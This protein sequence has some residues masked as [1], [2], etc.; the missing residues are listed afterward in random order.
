MTSTARVLLGFAVIGTSLLS[1]SFQLV[2]AQSAGDA[3]TT[4]EPNL[5]EPA[6]S[7]EPASEA[8]AL[9]IELTPTRVDVVPSPTRTVDGYTLEEMDLRV[10]RAR[11]GLLST[12]GAAVVGAVVL[13]TSVSCMR[14]RPLE[15]ACWGHFYSGVVLTFAGAVGMITTGSMLGVRKGKRRRLQEGD[16]GRPRKVQWDLAKSRLV[17]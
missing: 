9:Q 5:Q 15:T 6:P 16:Y 3:A 1:G 12:T 17:F 11:I 2:G 8:P 7:S 10:R 4:P 13:G 14:G